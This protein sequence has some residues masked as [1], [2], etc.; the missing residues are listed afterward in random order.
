[1][2]DHVSFF[3]KTTIRNQI[4]EFVLIVIAQEFLIHKVPPFLRVIEMIDDDDI[5]VSLPV[6]HRADGAS[7]ESGST[8]DDDSIRFHKLVIKDYLT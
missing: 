5:A 8:G 4:K 1:M 7:Y 2:D 6:Q 3:K